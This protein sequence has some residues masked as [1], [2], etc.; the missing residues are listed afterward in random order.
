MGRTLRVGIIGGG[1]GGLALAATLAKVGIESRLFE[2]APAFGEVGAGLQMT[3]N[4]VKVIRELGGSDELRKVSFLPRSIVGRNW[5]SGKVAFRTPLIDECPRLYD[6]EFLHTHRADLH[7]ILLSLAPSN[8]TTLSAQ[9]VSVNQSND[10]AVATFADHSEFE[11]DLIV[12]ADGIQSTV[13]KSLF[14][15]EAPRFTGNMCWRML[16]PFERPDF[17]LVSPDAS[18]WLGPQGHVVTYYVSGGRA[19]NVVAIREADAWVEESWNIR[20]NRDELLAG[21]PNWHPQVLD[22]FS[23]AE[24]I[25]KWGLFDRDPMSTWSAGRLTLLGDAAH[26]ML[27]FLSQGAAMA[28]EDGYVLGAVLAENA[29]LAVALKRY[30]ALRLPR[31]SRVQLESRKRG[32]TY[33]ISSPL[34][35]LYRDALY[36]LR[37]MVNPQTTGIQADWVYSYDAISE[38]RKQLN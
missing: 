10:T 33:H 28:I 13:R 35:R 22:L 1:I 20:S 23:R 19:V 36:R 16:I 37:Q 18:F 26:P 3:P 24:N 38:P 9:C 30:E 4:A 32:E 12:G 34:R 2:R 15:A 31:T 8:S 6:A 7:R 29:D 25:F 21:Y 11:A 17:D 14:G 27:P 5:H